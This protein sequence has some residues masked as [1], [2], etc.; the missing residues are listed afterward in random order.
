[1]RSL[2]R[3][4]RTAAIVLAVIALGFI[5]LDLG[6]GSLQNAH[7]GVRGF[8]GSLYRGT[9]AVIGPA[10]RWAQGV[11]S[12]GSHEGEIRAL[13]EDNA[14][15]KGQLAAARDD[16]DVAAQLR[17]L[18]RATGDGRT[19]KSA[20][21]TAYGPGQGFDW[22]I[23]IDAGRSAGVRAGQTVTDGGGLVGRVLNADA[24]SAVV[25][26]AADP[27][28][29]VG[30]RDTRSRE[31][32]VVTGAGDDGFTLRPIDPKA[33]LRAGDELLTGPVA[34]TSYA[35]GLPVGTITS[36]RRSAD[37]TVSAAVRPATS[38]T[39][40]DVVGVLVDPPASQASG[41]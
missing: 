12:A 17:K 13:R 9:D 31:L 41:R 29:G 22:T 14:K 38:P 40:V 6:G 7:S 5:T 32:G 19:V 28:S 34:E 10:R 16:D 27:G 23:T 8:F 39:A 25:L 21:V 24:D 36:V 26:L 33:S 20:R 15:L 1:M 4:Q 2:T 30:V 11:P 18:E 37:G 3:R 35:P